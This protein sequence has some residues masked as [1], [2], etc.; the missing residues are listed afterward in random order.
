MAPYPQLVREPIAE[1]ELAIYGGEPV[2]KAPWPSWP[3][4]DAETAKNLL[5]VLYSGR[6]AISGMY[7]G[8][9]MYERRFAEEFAR[10]HG[11][12][13]CVPVCNGSAALTV[14][15]EALGVGHGSEVLVPGLT[16]V[17]CA[18]SV[19]GI[20]AVPVLVDV[21][22]ETLCMSAEEARKAITPRTSAILLVHLYC[23]IADIEGFVQLSRET[24][25]PLIEDC[26]QAHGAVWK[27]R[28]VGTY[29]AVGVFSMQDSKVL[30][31]GEGGAAITNDPLLF[32]R[33]QQLR[34]DG[35]RYTPNPPKS[36]FQELE[37]AGEIQGRNYCL[38]EFQAAVALDR[39][40]HLDEENALR[41]RNA[42]Y[43]R[44]RLKAIDG[45]SPLLVRPGT[46]AT[47]YYQFCF[48]MDTQ[49]FGRNVE[50]IR[51]ALMAELELF[52]EAADA[53][54]NN[55]V[56][57]NPVRS[58]R[59]HPEVRPRLDPAIWL[60]PVADAMAKCCFTFPHRALLG[61]QS[62]MDDI[63]RAFHKVLA[64]RENSFL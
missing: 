39:L 27:G 63:V 44:E 32:D 61:N 15:M 46:D 45:V 50:W 19:A 20:G 24:G 22:P 25:I 58:P 36:G 43:L 5:D 51:R 62:D 56:L 29:G 4:A 14:A 38:S 53:P 64:A 7:N 54:L 13:Y 28:R 33:M 18:S 37:E 47:T 42:N 1:G 57:Y 52:I 10:F 55:N 8:S 35:R 3:K 49:K 12:R 17:A 31:C 23:T 21:E 26:S 16:W 40:Q 60:L 30:T 2:R 34:G 11:V 9:K 41:E 48:K 59:S 6:W